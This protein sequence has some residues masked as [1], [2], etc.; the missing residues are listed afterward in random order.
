MYELTILWTDW[1]RLNE[2]AAI[3]VEICIASLLP[4]VIAMPTACLDAAGSGDVLIPS[5]FLI[6]KL[7]EPPGVYDTKQKSTQMGRMG[8]GL[9]WNKAHKCRDAK[10][11]VQDIL[12]G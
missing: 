2:F 1:I 5:L 8:N 12:G 7:P 9:P 3:V 4:G 11:K 10:R 6:Q